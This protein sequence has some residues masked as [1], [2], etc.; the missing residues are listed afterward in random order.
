MAL[1]DTLW[2]GSTDDKLYLQ[3]GQYTSTIKTSIS[4][5]GIEGS[6]NG[7]SWDGTNTPV[8]GSAGAKLYLYSGQFTSTLKTSQGTTHWRSL[9]YDGMDTPANSNTELIRFS[10]QFTT[11][12]KDS[13]TVGSIDNVSSG[14]S[15]DGTNTLWC[16]NQ[17]DKLYLQSGNFTST[18]KTSQDVSGVELGTQDIASNDVN[19]RIVAVIDVN[20]F[21][22]VLG[23]T[24]ALL[25]PVITGTSMIVV[26]GAAL[27]ITAAV[28][29]PIVSGG[30]TV[31]VPALTL[32][33]AQMGISIQAGSSVFVSVSSLSLSIAVS[34]A[35]TIS[36]EPDTSIPLQALG[37][38]LHS[39]TVII[40][41]DIKTL[42]TNTRNFA[43]SEYTNFTFNSMCKFNGK[44]LYA[45]SNGIYEGGGDSDNGTNIDA[46]YK[47]GAVDI[48]A[49][50]IQRLR[51]A[52]LTFRSNGDI[53]LFSVGDEIYTRIYSII[54]SPATTIHERRI[55]FERGIKDRH[56]NFGI[57]N[58]NGSTLEVDS[59][60]ILTEPL[61]K[62]R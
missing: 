31:T 57:S 21:P 54:G 59:A 40:S 3:S 19:G 7:I 14:I 6:V 39:P 16:G 2:C 25:S 46:S 8:C 26:I 45:K 17:A 23:L 38:S 1:I 4:I 30:A 41:D 36:G 28:V 53:Q 27:A 24:G 22:S 32:G 18:L 49:T 51:D 47:T 61:R 33:L 52:Y 20:V 37:L 5:S 43:I 13:E 55:K 62:R 34:G 56:F 60:K 15:Y 42:V 35:P 9:S 29:S 11:T 44:F 50:E 48:Y 12:V 10:G 58:I